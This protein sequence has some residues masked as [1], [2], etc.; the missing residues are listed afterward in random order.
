MNFFFIAE[1]IA[2]VENQQVCRRRWAEAENAG[3]GAKSKIIQL[4]SENKT[5]EAKYKHARFVIFTGTFQD[6]FL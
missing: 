3:S 1:F 6:V 4:E 2:F 5:L